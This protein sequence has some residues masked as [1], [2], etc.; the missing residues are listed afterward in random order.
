MLYPEG[1]IQIQ[2]FILMDPFGYILQIRFFFGGG[3]WFSLWIKH[4]EGALE[5]VPWFSHVTLV[6]NTMFF[7][8]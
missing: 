4:M 3:G 7:Y 5:T 8:L 1:I 6:N 2:I